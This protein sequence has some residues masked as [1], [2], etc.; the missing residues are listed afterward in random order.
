MERHR[1]R[2]V[3][4]ESIHELVEDFRLTPAVPN[5]TMRAC[6]PARLLRGG[7]HRVPNSS[8]AKRYG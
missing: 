2:G 3:A 7:I 1:S 4:R 5:L 6:D 8:G